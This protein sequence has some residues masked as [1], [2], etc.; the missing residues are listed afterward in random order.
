MQNEVFYSAETNSDY[1]LWK[2]DGTATGTYRV[3]NINI[4]GS[5]S[6]AYLTNVNGSLF[7]AAT[8]QIHGNELWVVPKPV[9]NTGPAYK[10]VEGTASVL[11][12]AALSSD[13]DPTQY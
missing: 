1:E 4:Y 3:K 8:D 6:P 10:I 5:S 12:S 2:S 7:F 9:A 13:L 11:L